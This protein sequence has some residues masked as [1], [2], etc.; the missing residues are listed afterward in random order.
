MVAV[1]VRHQVRDYAAWKPIFDEHGEVRRRHGAT[2]HRLYRVAGSPTDLI[3]VNQFPSIEQA[4]AALDDPSLREAMARAGVE[5]TPDITI[6][7]EVEVLSYEPA[8]V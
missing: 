1:I 2:G 3:I 5:G 8:A 7:D 6:V 4:Q